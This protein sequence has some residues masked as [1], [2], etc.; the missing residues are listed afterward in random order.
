MAAR[1]STARRSAGDSATGKSLQLREPRPKKAGAIIG[2]AAAA[3]EY[4]GP[5]LAGRDRECFGVLFLDSQN[6]LIAA[7]ELFRGTL[8]QVAVYPREIVRRAMALNCA[9]VILVHNHPSGST[10][11]SEADI[12]VT[13]AVRMALRL[14]DCVLL[15]HIIVGGAGCQSMGALGLIDTPGADAVVA[16]PA[17]A[18][19]D[20]KP[21]SVDSLHL[22]RVDASDF[23]VTCIDDLR[24]IFK[25]IQSLAEKGTEVHSLA[26]VGVYLGGDWLGLAESMRD[27]AHRAWE[28]QRARTAESKPAPLPAPAV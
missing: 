2:T 16:A 24:G 23:G 5:W 26:K 17:P 8:G 4:A 13:A 19:V 21:E 25:A 27:D 3:M 22:A 6:R 10:E 11:P 9:S 18:S 28:K 7:E 1:H 15:D 20:E 12:K 14:V